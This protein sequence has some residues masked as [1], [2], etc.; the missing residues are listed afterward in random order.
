M[1]SAMALPLC[2]ILVR[3]G[4]RPVGTEPHSQRLERAVRPGAVIEARFPPAQAQEAFA[5]AGARA[6]K[7]WI[8]RGGEQASAHQY[9]ARPPLAS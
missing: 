2:L 7:T 8:A 3:L 9:V 1:S 6:G 4:I 5:G